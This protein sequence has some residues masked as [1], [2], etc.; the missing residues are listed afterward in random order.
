MELNA[1]ISL[2]EPH[3]VAITPR[4]GAR[5]VI[6]GKMNKYAKPMFQ[7]PD[8]GFM[9]WVKKI[10]DKI[11]SNDNTIEYKRKSAFS[12]AVGGL[13]WNLSSSTNSE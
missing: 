6:P 12:L 2:G 3:I 10:T 13:P 4:S 11:N 8:I 5:I 7:I 1:I 9:M